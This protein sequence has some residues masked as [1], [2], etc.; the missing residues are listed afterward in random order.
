MNTQEQIV[1]AVD[2]GADYIIAE[3]FNSY[4]EAQIALEA[5]IQYGNGETNV[6]YRWPS[7]TVHLNV[8]GTKQKRVVSVALFF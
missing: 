7:F 2:G 5:I 6:F 4:G 8:S 3:T 1:W